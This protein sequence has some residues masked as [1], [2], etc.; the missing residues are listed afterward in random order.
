MDI[1]VIGDIISIVLPRRRR[2]RQQPDRGHAEVLQIIELL[3]QAA[4]IAHAVAVAVVKRS[5]VQLVDD[6][7]FVPERVVFEREVFFAIRQV[8]LQESIQTAVR[9]ALRR[10][11]RKIC[12]GTLAGLSSTKLRAPCQI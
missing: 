2:K 7:V 12:A 3:R 11:T 8:A 4:E 6:R 5:H 10:S 9:C 1:G